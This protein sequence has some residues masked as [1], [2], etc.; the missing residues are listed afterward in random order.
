MS[1]FTGHAAVEAPHTNELSTFVNH[2]R[3]RTKVSRQSSNAPSGLVQR[4]RCGRF[5][6]CVDRGNKL[7]KNTISR[8]TVASVTSLHT[9]Q[10]RV[11]HLRMPQAVSWHSPFMH[12]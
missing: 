9:F 8:T 4:G 7:L 3:T 5:S 10:S 12:P 2:H 11:K 6:G 1:V